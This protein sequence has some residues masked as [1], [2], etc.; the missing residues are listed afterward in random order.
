MIN[1]SRELMDLGLKE[2]EANV[3]LSALE[4]GPSPVQKIAEKAG[5]NRAT[6]YTNI[7]VLMD[8][9]LMSTE[10]H[11][12][13]TYYKSESPE[14]LVDI[15]IKREEELLERQ[16]RELEE[17][18]PELKEIQ[19]RSLKSPIV[20]YFEGKEGVMSMV[21]EVFQGKDTILRVVYPEQDIHVFSKADIDQA[22]NV[23]VKKN[24][25]AKSILSTHHKYNQENLVI[26][27]GEILLFT[28]EE[29]PVS[30]D[31]A[32]FADQIRIITFKEPI[33]GIVIQHKGI[34]DSFKQIFDLLFD[35]LLAD[36]NVVR[37]KGKNK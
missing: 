17:I 34:T 27:N 22:A 9:G 37:Y 24:I 18:L 31:I 32:F 23:R 12:K 2:K 28:P 16:E 4:L 13:K 33:I 3:Y 26:H 19:A 7:D 36:D 29:L 6:A 5:V 14:K 8:I 25:Y 35:L 30:C 15:L 11:G 10:K 21:N 1:L 20:R